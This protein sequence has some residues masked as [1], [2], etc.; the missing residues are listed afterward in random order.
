ML[1]TTLLA[2]GA[3]MLAAT[4]ASA[5]DYDGPETVEVIAPRI[6]H[7]NSALAPTSYTNL[8]TVVRYDDL[9][10][11]TR[12]GAGELRARIRDAAHDVCEEL[13][14]RYPHQLAGDPPCYKT[15]VDK[16]MA[17]A[18]TAIGSARSYTYAG[19]EE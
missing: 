8:S 6:V 18:D 3:L 4:A 16:A 19:Y 5:Q 17:R 10:L 14:Y 15:A 9:D 1:K 11:R 7:D 13:K 12:A 2:A